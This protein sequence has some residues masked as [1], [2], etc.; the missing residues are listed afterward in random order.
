M[1]FPDSDRGFSE[2]GHTA[3]GA[4]VV[5]AIFPTPWGALIPVH[6][7]E[8]P[9]YGVEAAV[10]EMIFKHGHSASR[11]S[12][13]GAGNAR[14]A[15]RLYAESRISIGWQ[16]SWTILLTGRSGPFGSWVLHG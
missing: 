15:S 11:C 4:I 13:A 7:T 5:N 1:Q 8:N 14:A 6:R 10:C 9:P 16:P 3:C 2:S 12:A